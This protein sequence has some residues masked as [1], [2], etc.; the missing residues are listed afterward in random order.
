LLTDN[1]IRITDKDNDLS[2]SAFCCSLF[3][4]TKYKEYFVVV[5]VKTKQNNKMQKQKITAPRHVVT[6]C[7][8]ANFLFLFCLAQDMLSQH[9][10]GG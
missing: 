5:F 7:L 9:V 2:L 8:G 3:F 10:L 4:G 6:T 1:D